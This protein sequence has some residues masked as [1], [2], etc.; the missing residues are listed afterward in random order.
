MKV[1]ITRDK[2]DFSQVMAQMILKH[3]YS[4]KARVN[5]SITAGNTPIRGY[6]ILAESVRGRNYFDNVHYYVFDDI[7]IR[8]DKKEI[9]RTTAR[10][11]EPKLWPVKNPNAGIVR[12]NL[13]W[14]YFVPAG[15]K[16]DRI[17]DITEE[18]YGDIDRMIAQA[19]GLDMIIMG[20]GPDGHI[21]GNLPGTVPY[22]NQGARKVRAD[23]TPGTMKMV[24]SC[25]DEYH[26]T[27]ES[28]LPEYYVSFG[29]KTVLDARHAILI[30]TGSEKADIVRRVLYD[31]VSLELPASVLQ[32]HRDLTVL[33][34]QEA[35]ADIM[36][37][38]GNQ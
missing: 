11:E 5:L 21:C 31:P 30:A 17:H 12:E 35:A 22:W 7:F 13:D 24:R 2:E 38:I 23:T 1:Y 28:L 10:G 6:E 32:L 27:D 16:D 25:L 4:G 37:K 18:N 15:V 29:P 20:L 8:G 26:L 9:Y 36:D 14:K 19:G 33:L 34:D 3:M